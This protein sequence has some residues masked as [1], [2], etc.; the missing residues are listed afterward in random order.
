[1]FYKKN[2]R[3]IKKNEGGNRIEE[4]NQRKKKGSKMENWTVSEG[5]HTQTQ[6]CTR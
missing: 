5:P 1:M 3:K 2:K 6:N 4:V